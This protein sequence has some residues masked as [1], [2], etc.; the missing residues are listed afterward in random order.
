MA[1]NHIEDIIQ[2]VDEMGNNSDLDLESLNSF[3]GFNECDIPLSPCAN[4]YHSDIDI[5]DIDILDV[6][7]SNSNSESKN[8]NNDQGDQDNPMTNPE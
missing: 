4:L 5:A 1:E 8:E 7:S 3:D 2:E 6:H